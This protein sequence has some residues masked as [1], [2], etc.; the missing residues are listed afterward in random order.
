MAE[1]IINSNKE[2]LGKDVSDRAKEIIKSDTNKKMKNVTK[3]V[4]TNEQEK[5]KRAGR[6]RKSA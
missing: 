6:P 2:S 3:E 1:T 5:V 4:K